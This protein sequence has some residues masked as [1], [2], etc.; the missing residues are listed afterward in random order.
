MTDLKSLGYVTVSTTDIDHW[1]KLAL[2]VLGFAEG[3]GPEPSALYLRV[4][5]R[6]VRIIGVPG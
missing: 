1:R 6:A 3:S 2:G 4:A 5:E